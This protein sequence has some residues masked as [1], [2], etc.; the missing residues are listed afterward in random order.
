M[1]LSVLGTMRILGPSLT[2]TTSQTYLE[3]RR[4]RCRGPFHFPDESP[5]GE[6]QRTDRQ[7]THP[8]DRD[9]DETVLGPVS[10]I[11]KGDK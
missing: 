10:V 6:P 8:L 2:K 11:K 4:D 1:R 5:N 9:P 3:Q 7:S